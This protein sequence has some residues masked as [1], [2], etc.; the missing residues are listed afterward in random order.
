MLSFNYDDLKP[1]LMFFATVETA[2]LLVGGVVNLLLLTYHLK[3]PNKS[4]TVVLYC[5]MNGTDLMI[6]SLMV[7]IVISCWSGSKPLLF[8][9]TV[10]REIWL[11]IW[12][13]S[14]RTSVFL[15]GLQ[16]VL[17][18]RAL[19]FPFSRRIKKGALAVI[20]VVYTAILCSL[21]SVRLSY[22]VY[23]VFSKNTN[24]PTVVWSW[25]QKAMGLSSTTSI[26]FLVLNNFFGYVAPF[27]PI[28]ISCVISVYCIRRSGRGVNSPPG[29]THS[30][31]HQAATRTV[32]LLTLVYIV[33]NALIFV[34]ELNEMLV[35]F[36]KIVKKTVHFIDWHSEDISF[37][38]F[39]LVFVTTYNIC[40]ILNST[41]NGLVFLIR[42]AS[43]KCFILKVCQ[44]V[45]RSVRSKEDEPEIIM[46]NILVAQTEVSRADTLA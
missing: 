1:Q 44:K 2:G 5:L 14:G 22:K 25:V 15:I 30:N 3:Q 41:L 4:T 45:S 32:I 28:T 40:V 7:P 13:V 33:T 23:S 18:T 31:N 8:E 37:L 17:R 36:S 12:E 29:G 20:I 11:F 35:S 6:C 21:Q 16:S 27:L 10:V 38:Q 9:T 24:R 39:L 46:C 43:I 19:L 26:I 34:V 42:T